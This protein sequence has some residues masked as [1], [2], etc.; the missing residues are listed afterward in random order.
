MQSKDFM[1]NMCIWMV[2]RFS[3]GWW[4]IL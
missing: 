1:R 3:N 4:W 2:Y